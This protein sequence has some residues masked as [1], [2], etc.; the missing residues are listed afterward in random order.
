MD[1]RIVPE[2]RENASEAALEDSAIE[3]AGDRLVVEPA[4][5]SVTRL[6]ALFPQELHPLVELLEDPEQRGR[7]RISRA[8]GRDGL[9]DGK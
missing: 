9:K 2:V 7:L 8:V 3:V 1:V 4:P 6:E 5:G